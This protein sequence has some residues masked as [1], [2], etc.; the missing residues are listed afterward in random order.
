M[1]K[2]HSLGLEFPLVNCCC[3]RSWLERWLLEHSHCESPAAKEMSGY[4]GIDRS[5]G[6]NC[7]F[8]VGA[9]GGCIEPERTAGEWFRAFSCMTDN[10]RVVMTRVGKEVI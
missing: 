1:I 6:D 9:F 2:R 10:N 8:V 7:S 5:T 3:A 4:T